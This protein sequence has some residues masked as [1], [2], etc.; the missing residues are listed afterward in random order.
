MIA[1]IMAAG[2]G[3]R[4][5]NHLGHPKHLISI[6]GETLL[7]RQ[8]RLLGLNGVDDVSIMGPTPRDARYLVKGARYIEQSEILRDGPFEFALVDE[9]GDIDRRVISRRVPS[10][11]LLGDVYY[12]RLAMS[13]ICSPLGPAT[14]AWYGRPGYPPFNNKWFNWGELWAIQLTPESVDSFIRAVVHI[15][16]QNMNTRDLFTEMMREVNPRYTARDCRTPVSHCIGDETSDFDTP[17]IYEDWLS[18]RQLMAWGCG[19]CD[20]QI[21]R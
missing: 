17:E 5:N 3:S 2:T 21:P 20:A 16:N 14:F 1:T 6:D 12:S 9:K 7:Q 15:R 4:W 19:V 18:R 8:V 11:I 10:I 13:V